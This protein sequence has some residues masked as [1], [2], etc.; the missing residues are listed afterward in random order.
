MRRP[1][2]GASFHIER[3][4]AR[5]MQVT[6]YPCA[7]R[8]CHGARIMGGY[9][10]TRHHRRYGRDPFLPH[11][12]LVSHLQTPNPFLSLM[13]LV[14]GTDRGHIVHFSVCRSYD[15]VHLWLNS[16]AVF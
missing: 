4:V 14:V 3:G 7:C 12:V 16:E 10:I 11:P 8:R 5:R 1:R 15:K 2:L 13:I 6:E 9:M